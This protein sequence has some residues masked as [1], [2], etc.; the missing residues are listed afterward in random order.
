MRIMP[1]VVSSLIFASACVSPENAYDP[2]TDPARQARARVEG[3]V[4]LVDPNL[5]AGALASEAAG[6]VVTLVDETSK[7]VARAA[8]ADLDVEG[9]AARFT[10]ADVVPGVYTLVIGELHT[11]F[12]GSLPGRIDLLPGSDVDVGDMRFVAPAIPEGQGSNVVSGEVRVTSGAVGPRVVELFRLSDDGARSLRTATTDAEGRFRFEALSPGTYAVVGSAENYTPAYAMDLAVGDQPGASP[13]LLLA[14]DAA[15]QLSPVSAVLGFSDEV[16]LVEGQ[17]YT[18]ADSVTLMVSAFGGE[19]VVTGMRLATD[20]A[21]L[22]DAG[23]PL[24]FESFSASRSL[25]LPD[26]EGP[27]VIHAQ[28]EARSDGGFVFVSPLF[29]AVVVRDV[30]PPEVISAVVSGGVLAENGSHYLTADVVAPAL[31]IDASDAVSAVSGVAVVESASEPTLDDDAFSE[32]FAPA[33]LAYLTAPLALSGGDGEKRL[34]VALRD[35]AGNR[36][37][38]FEIVV[39]VDTEPPVVDAVTLAGGASFLLTSQASVEVTTASADVA[40]VAL[41][42]GGSEPVSYVPYL[43]APLA[44]ALEPGDGSRPVV[45]RLRDFAGNESGDVTDSIVV[46]GGAAVLAPALSSSL[47]IPLEVVARAAAEVRLALGSASDDG[48]SLL[49]AAS[50]SASAPS[51]LSAD[52]DG[53][54]RVFAQVRDATGVESGLLVAD[55]LVDTTAPAF[56]SGGVLVDQGASATRFVSVTVTIDAEDPSDVEDMAVATDG[57]V[58]SES[59][60]PFAPTITALLPPNDCADQDPTAPDECKSV[61]VVLRDA[62]GN[63]SSSSCDAIRLDTTPPTT[64]AITPLFATVRADTVEIRVIEP[65]TDFNGEPVSTYEIRS[66]AGDYFEVEGEG[67][68]RFRLRPNRQNE[69]C[70]RGRDAAGNVG[71]EDCAVVDE[72][73]LRTVLANGIDSQGTDI[74]GDFLAFAGR[75]GLWLHDLRRDP[76]E[77]YNDP[78]LELL[79][80]GLQTVGFASGTGPFV[81]LSGDPRTLVVLHGPHDA[82]SGE[83]AFNVY[84]KALDERDLIPGGGQDSF[85]EAQIEG[86]SFDSDGRYVAYAGK[87]GVYVHDLGPNANAIDLSSPIDPTVATT[88]EKLVSAPG[89]DTCPGTSPRVIRGVIV[90]CQLVVGE[91]RVMRSVTTNAG[92]PSTGSDDV[93]ML[94]QISGADPVAPT[95]TSIFEDA[96]FMQPVLSERYVAWVE[97]GANG[98]N[99]VLLQ[100]GIGAPLAQTTRMEH[101]EP[102]AARNCPPLNIDRIADFSGARLAFFTV[103]DTSLGLTDVAVVDFDLPGEKAFCVTKDLA[104]QDIASIDG[105]R[106][107]YRDVTNNESVV[108]ADLS[109][110]R[111]LSAT[112]ELAFEPV[113]SGR[114]GVAAWIETRPPVCAVDGDCLVAQGERCQEGACTGQRRFITLVARDLTLSDPG[115]ELLIDQSIAFFGPSEADPTYLVGGEQLAWLG[116]AGFFSPPPF[117]L[118]VALVSDPATRLV[119]TENAAKAI[120]IDPEGRRVAYVDHAGGADQHGFGVLKLATLGAS[121]VAGTVTIDAIASEIPYVDVERLSNVAEDAVVV[122]QRGGDIDDRNSGGEMFV[123]VAGAAGAEVPI[124]DRLGNLIVTTAESGRVRGPKVARVGNDLWV[125]YLLAPTS[126]FGLEPHAC[127]LRLSAPVACLDDEKLG[128]KLSQV[129][130]IGI[131]RDG[132]VAFVS[133]EEDLD[134]IVLFDVRARRRVWATPVAHAA[135]DRSTPDIAAGHLVWAD[136]SLGT[137]DVFEMV[138]SP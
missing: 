120:G 45:A 11:R 17:R 68:F 124:A 28:F 129:R 92:D 61:C 100:G 52:G 107:I 25:S 59:F 37:E 98:H 63:A 20:D 126:G 87:G 105:G 94:E 27:I 54:W 81:R 7:E 78:D 51:T 64:P 75:G 77:S 95:L 88:T 106:L 93:R 50:Y 104:P 99:V 42:R 57:V 40:A 130:D 96:G 36:S 47:D 38:A 43:S 66:P 32:L 22:D 29:R 79:T 89:A 12:I 41:A 123:S 18:S 113:T 16:R 76:P 102:L 19:N 69:L 118:N 1:V 58:D 90:W 80:D 122:W 44:F 62:A 97:A 56:G 14:G 86:R 55:V 82:A 127:R 131:S 5:D 133:D 108:L 103:N 101:A 67:P 35:R 60:Q 71:I 26:V 110:T 46:D 138:L 116:N 65:A 53:P 8:G 49:A 2:D 114:G 33:G 125:A 72:Q 74:F 31:Q 30:T 34:F 134:E 24:L 3:R 136:A 137:P 73:T 128:V 9:G 83:K 21:F 111:W 135:G 109:R 117:T 4:V 6:L 121:A 84:V 15:L 91:A 48:L 85:F 132:L 23:A 119:V 70:V 39:V 13:D 10:L 112:P 115:P